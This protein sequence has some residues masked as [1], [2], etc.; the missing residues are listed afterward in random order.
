MA[1][2]WPQNSTW[3]IFFKKFQE[4]LVAKPQNVFIFVDFM[5]LALFFWKQ[6]N[7]SRQR[8]KWWMN[9]RWCRKCFYFLLNILNSFFLFFYFLENSKC[10]N[11]FG[12][13]NEIF[14]KIH[15]LII[16]QLLSFLIC[17]SSDAIIKYKQCCQAKKSKWRLNSRWRWKYFFIFHIISHRFKVVFIFLPYQKYYIMSLLNEFIEYQKMRTFHSAIV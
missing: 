2:K 7:A 16:A 13:N 1:L 4:F 6:I 17:C 12:I 10:R 5:L 14:Q 15:D 9:S 8:S 11:N 3:Q